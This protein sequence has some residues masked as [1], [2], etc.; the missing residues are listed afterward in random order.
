MFYRTKNSAYN[1]KTDAKFK[2]LFLKKR[3]S[4]RNY[5]FYFMTIFFLLKS[6]RKIRAI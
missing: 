4:S 2:N 1:T 3:F 6:H 5:S